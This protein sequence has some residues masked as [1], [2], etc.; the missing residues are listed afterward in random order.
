MISFIP[1]IMKS[2][3][4]RQCWRGF[5]VCQD[6]GPITNYVWSPIE[7]KNG[8]RKEANFIRANLIVLDFDSGR[9]M[10]DVR[11]TFVDTRHLIATTKSHTEER[12][13][14]RLLL[15][16]RR[17]IEDIQVYKYNIRK[18]ADEQDADTA[19]TDGG[20]FFWPSVEIRYWDVG[21]SHLSWLD[22]LTPPQS[23]IKKQEKIKERYNG[24]V[25]GLTNEAMSV[26]MRDIPVGER[27][28]TWFKGCK[29]I[30]RGGRPYDQMVTQ[31]QSTPT[32]LS[33][34]EA[35]RRSLL[36]TAESARGSLMRSCS[37]GGSEAQSL[38]GG[39]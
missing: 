30:L 12:H 38:G 32:F 31:I 1:R 22:I 8:E 10:E 25:V 16:P 26:L 11:D 21:G 2:R 24:P 39:G 19:C 35:D 4:P 13:R 3:D 33:A 6:I 29:D 34:D 5:I 36:R 15:W 17:P 28:D 9:T 37:D 14:F 20:R 18:L 27:N 7:W 23:W